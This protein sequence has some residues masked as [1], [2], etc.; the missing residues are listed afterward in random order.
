VKGRKPS[1]IIEGS[2]TEVPRAPAWMSPAAKSEWKRI[3]PDLVQRRTLEPADM[4]L[5]E[6]LCVA[7]GRVREIEKL[8]RASGTIDA[9]MFRMQDKAMVTARQI[10][11]EIGATPV[12]RSRACLRDDGDGDDLSFLGD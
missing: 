4:G 1:S 6:F 12:A 9:R 3:M 7:L 2:I 5:V 8:I 10:A 11:S